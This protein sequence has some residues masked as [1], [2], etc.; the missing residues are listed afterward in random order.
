MV[1]K[2]IITYSPKWKR[3]GC[4]IDAVIADPMLL[5]I[6]LAIGFSFLLI[7]IAILVERLAGWIK[8]RVSI[9]FKERDD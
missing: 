3:L 2:I 9:E 1:L 8:N 7:P 6:F 4:Y 5:I